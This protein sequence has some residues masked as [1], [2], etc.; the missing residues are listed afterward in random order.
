MSCYV[1]SA[2]MMTILD[3]QEVRAL[4]HFPNFKHAD[5]AYPLLLSM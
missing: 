5:I 2:L 3:L 1:L 4:M